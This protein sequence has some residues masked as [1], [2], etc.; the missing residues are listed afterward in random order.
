MIDQPTIDRI[1]DAATNIRCRI[2]L[3]YPAQTR[4]E[5]CGTVPFHELDK[6][7]LSMYPPPKGSASV[8]PAEGGKCSA[9]HHGARTDV[10]SWGAEISRQKYG[11][12]IKERE[13]SSEEKMAQSERGSSSLLN[14]F[15]RDYFQNILKNHV[16]GQSIGMAISAAAAGMTSSRSSSWA[17]VPRAAT[18][19]LPGKP[20]KKAIKDY[21]VKT[22]LCYDGRPLT[23][24][25]LLGGHLP[26]HTSP[27]K[28]AFGD[29]VPGESA[30]KGRQGEIPRQLAWIG[31]LS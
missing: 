11:I 30:T 22:G 12:E 17:I 18:M 27:A 5:L 16:D 1:L 4:R 6:P 31:N 7:L 20:L 23:A 13:L 19:P 25:P 8:L 9:F 15:A 26:V 10:L 14:N 3:R 24:R 2:G 28:V 29:D 21:L